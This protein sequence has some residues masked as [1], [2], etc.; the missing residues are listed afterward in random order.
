M[1]ERHNDSTKQRNR[2]VLTEIPTAPGA[3]AL[4]LDIPHELAVPVAGGVRLSSGQY[5]Y[6]GSA[7]GP[8]GIRARVARHL[9]AEKTAHWHIDRLHP[10]DNSIAVICVDGGT[11][12]AMV[13]A[14][15]RL[16][17]A[18]MPIS[19]FGAS[20][21]AN[22]AA[23]LIRLPRATDPKAIADALRS[24]DGAP[25]LIDKLGTISLRRSSRRASH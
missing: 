8:G 1:A 2:R 4:I 9:R 12:C 3:Y 21:C 5:V 13:E 7:R 18:T 17:G 22:C 15:M 20:D 19:G 25:M 10:Q 6:C 14:A 11:E 16:D 24:E 23:H